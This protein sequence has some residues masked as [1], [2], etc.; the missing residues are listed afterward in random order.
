MK[1]DTKYLLTLAKKNYYYGMFVCKICIYNF[2]SNEK[3]PKYIF[4]KTRQDIFHQ[5]HYISF[6]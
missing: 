3:F 6:R 1:M 4:Y 2:D 5:F